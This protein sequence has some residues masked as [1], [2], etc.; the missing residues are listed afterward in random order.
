MKSTNLFQQKL[1]FSFEATSFIKV[2]LIAE[3]VLI[4]SFHFLFVSKFDL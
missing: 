3:F 2:I 4:M 1:I